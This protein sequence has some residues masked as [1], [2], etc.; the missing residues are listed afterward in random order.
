MNSGNQCLATGM[1]SSTKGIPD[2]LKD[3]SVLRL[4]GLAQYFMMP[5]HESRHFVRIFLRKFRT[6]FDVCKKKCNGT[7]WQTGHALSI[8]VEEDRFKANLRQFACLL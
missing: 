5:R 6:A 7:A 2:N 3:I 4:N 8:Q 1:K